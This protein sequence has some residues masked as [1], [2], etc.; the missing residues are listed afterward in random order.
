MDRS[1]VRQVLEGRGEQGKMEE[2][3]CVVICGAPATLAVKGPVKVK[4]INKHAL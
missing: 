1:R 2:T 3:G 4:V